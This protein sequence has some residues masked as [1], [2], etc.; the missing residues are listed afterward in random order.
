MTLRVCIVDGYIDEPSG[1]GVPPYLDVYARYSAGAV[2]LAD[3]RAEVLYL[4]VDQLRSDISGY[5]K[6]LSKLD[7][8]IFIAGVTVPGSYLG[9]TPISFRELKTWSRL[10]PEPVKVLVGPVV[11]F[12]FGIEG[13]RAA[14]M[15]EELK[16][17]FDY[18]FHFSFESGLYELA[19]NC[20]KRGLSISTHE[21]SPKLVAEAA[22]RGVKIVGQ[23][24]NYGFNLICEVETYWGCPRFIVGGCSFCVE[25]LY[26]EPKFRA[27]EHVVCEV[28][29]LYEAG[30]RN[31]RLG[32]QPDILAYQSKEVG[33]EEFPKPNVEAIRKLFEGIRAVAPALETLHIDNVNPGTIYHHKEESVEAC[34]II[35][36]N[37]TSGDVAALG[38][39]SADPNVVKSNNLKVYPEEALEAIRVINSVGS[40]RGYNGLPHLLPGVNFVHGLKGETERTYEENLDFMKKVL[41]EGLMVRRVNIRQVMVFPNTPMWEVGDRIMKRNKRIFQA[42]KRRMRMEVDLPMIRR[43]LPT[44]SKLRGCYVEKH[45]GGGT[46]ARQAGSYPVL[47]F[48]PYSRGLGEKIDV[49]VTS[50]GFRSV[51]GIETPISVNSAPRK[52]WESIPGLSRNTIELILKK[53]PFKN[54]EEFESIVTKSVA[55]KLEVKL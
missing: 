23:H 46:Y 29:A 7:A 28:K 21:R 4:T 26:G 37:H 10:L 12:G 27:I 40:A 30:V 35:V 44:W 39:E 50:H 25:P 38:V 1:L 36:E 45:G 9:G 47:V 53:R 55:D 51:V 33:V 41:E 20:F 22:V 17:D 49:L 16:R 14:I 32:R 3:P 6:M 48:L 15:P 52:M 42:Y 5:L 54:V 19:L 18:M 8:V 34:K 11:S 31:I 43:V 24:P 2:W 13:G